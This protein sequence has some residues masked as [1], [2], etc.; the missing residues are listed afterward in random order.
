MRLGACPRGLS[1]DTLVLVVTHFAGLAHF[2]NILINVVTFFTVFEEH[3]CICILSPLLSLVPFCYTLFQEERI[4]WKIWLYAWFT[5]KI[6]R[7][8]LEIQGF[9]QGLQ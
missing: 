7:H 6:K 4:S 5:I 1:H 9:N 8:R 3:S 2:A